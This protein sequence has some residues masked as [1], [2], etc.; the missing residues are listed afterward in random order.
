MNKIKN[1]ALSYNEQ[2]KLNKIIRNKGLNQ[3]KIGRMLGISQYYISKICTG[4]TNITDRIVNQFLN[5][6]I[7][8]REVMKLRG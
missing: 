8:L 5:F 1:R 3:T 7:D 6:E 4:K 2:E